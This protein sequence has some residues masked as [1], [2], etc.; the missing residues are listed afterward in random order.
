MN[1]GAKIIIAMGGLLC[2]VTF[3]LALLRPGY[4]GNYFYLGALIF[5]ELMLVALWGFAQR[6][7]PVLIAVFLWA[8]IDVPWKDMW[9]TRRWFVLAIAAIAGLAIYLRSRRASFSGFHLTALACVL[10][11]LV[12]AMV[13]SQ[14]RAA[15]LKA[16]SLLMLFTYTAT[17]A[18]LAVLGREGKFFSGAL[19]GCE[20]IV[21]CGAGAYFVLRHHLFGNPNSLGAIFGV[22]V[23]P[24][25]AWG[26]FVSQEP[27]LYRRRSAAFLVGLVL[28][29]TSYSRAGIAAAA[30]SCGVLCVCLKRY[31]LLLRVMALS[32]AVAFLIATVSPIA[33]TDPGS[34]SQFIYKKGTG[35]GLLASRTSVWDET[36]G[37]IQQHPWFG[38]GF[39]TRATS[40]DNT[41]T[42]MAN[43]ASN[44][45]SREHGSSYLA[46]LE[47]VGLLGVV[48]FGALVLITLTRAVQVLIWFRRTKDLFSPAVPIALVMIAGL[49]H[50]G[51][52]DW[53]FAVGYYLCVFFWSLAFVMMDFLPAAE[54]RA[55]WPKDAVGVLLAPNNLDLAT[56]GN[57]SYSI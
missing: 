25:L 38:T 22:V 24:L 9:I 28:L 45:V 50:A 27:F 31:R 53:M 23:L 32:L 48:P 57:D 17:G 14:P 8:G 30:I 18:R 47:W 1:Q 19:I 42:A 55:V 35:K 6:F 40:Y 15:I 5:A 26:V 4:V 54:P 46:V 2:C 39:G 52:E 43:F 10:A 44:G 20:C 49:T 16:L 33:E 12:S 29:L 11:A 3:A 7:F 41:T 37:S 36:I 21:W 13:S 56:T 51:F 34:L